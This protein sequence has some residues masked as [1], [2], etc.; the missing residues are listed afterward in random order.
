[1][2]TRVRK[3]EVRETSKG[4]GVF[5][6][7]GI[8]KGQTVMSYGGRLISIEEMQAAQLAGENTWWCDYAKQ[9]SGTH[10]RIPRDRDDFGGHLVNHSCDPNAAFR[11][12]V[13]V[14]TRDLHEGE[15][16]TCCY[17]WLTEKE[18]HDCLCD[19]DVCAGIMG[20]GIVPLD[21]G[22]E[23]VRIRLR[24]ATVGAVLAAAVLNGR[25]DI[26]EQYS[27]D[28]L[29][30]YAQ[31]G[32]TREWV[33]ACGAW[34][35]AVMKQSRGSERRVMAALCAVEGAV[36]SGPAPPRDLIW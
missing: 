17:G 20:I 12:D 10:V 21:P 7:H 19:A 36:G 16:V 1:M 18:D 8:H 14:A 3:V 29:G 11:S 28:I 2:A 25:D 24:G 31:A 9:V 35:V 32:A 33:D 6:R 5:A 30:L 13:L 27:R 4:K 34:A 22:L 15:E 26:Y 23:A